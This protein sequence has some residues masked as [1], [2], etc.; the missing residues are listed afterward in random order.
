MAVG[1]TTNGVG[2]NELLSTTIQKIEG[3]LVDQTMQQHPTLDFFKEIISAG[4]GPSLIT[5]VR[6][7]LLGRT[8]TSDALGTFSTSVDGDIAGV[9]HYSY[10]NPIVTP[11][12]VAFLS[13]ALNEGSSRVVDIVKAHIEAA[14]ADHSVALAAAM[15]GNGAVAGEFNSLDDIV[16]ATGA[17]GGID[18]ATAAWWASTEITSSAA[19]E[20]I[21]VGFRRLSNGVLDAAGRTGDIL[22]VGADVFDEYEASLDDSVRY[23]ALG[24]GDTRFAELKFSGLTIRRDG[25]N[26]PA[27]NAYLLNKQALVAKNLRGHFLKPGA[28]QIKPGTMTEVTPF[29]TI[30]ATGTTERRAHGK[31][32]RTA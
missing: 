5:P 28:A 10:G 27:G 3:T 12:A 31:M 21:R 2:F 24:V 30:L 18:P 7:A 22:I 25:T 19:A 6:G 11:T 8:A 20:D 26:C 9:A 17:L 32:T 15:Y 16:S 4:E 14:I 1:G 29:S 13:I 23:N